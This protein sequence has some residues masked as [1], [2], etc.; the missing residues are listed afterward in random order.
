[1]PNFETEGEFLEEDETIRDNGL[2][3]LQAP[4]ISLNAFT[5][6]NNFKTL[7]VTGVLGKNKIHILIDYGSTHNFLDKNKA[8]QLRSNIRNMCP[9]SVTVAE[10]NKLV[11]TS[12][13]K[14]F[15]WQFGA[16][17]FTTDVMLLPLGGCDMREMLRGAHKS[18]LE[19]LSTKVSDK[20]IR[21]AELNFIDMCVFPN[22]ASTCM[23]LEKTTTDVHLI[24][25]EVIEEYEDV[26]AIPKELPPKRD[27]D[28]KIPLIEGAQPVNIR[29]YRHPPTQ[30]D[31]IEEMVT[32]LLQTRVIQNSNSPFSSL[33]VM[34]D[35]RFGYHQVR[36][37]DADIAKTAFK[38]HEGNYEFLVMPFGLTNA[39]FTFQSLMN[40]VF[41]QYLRKFVSVFFD[42]IL[43]Y[44]QIVEDHVLH[45]RAVLEIM[46]HHKLFAK[47]SKCVFGTDKVK[48]L[49][50]VIST[51]GVAT[52]PIKV[53]VMSQWPV[54][55]N[56]KQLRA[57]E[58]LKQAMV[59]ASVLKLS[60]FSKEFTLETDA[61]GVGLGAILLQEG[62][63]IAFLSK[64]LS[65][66]HQLMS[67]YEK[68][69]LAIIYALEK[70]RG[71]LLHSHF[72]IKTDHLS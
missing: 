69:F 21:Q 24:L 41:R 22:S 14:Q 6:S 48:Y 35:L 26:F 19:W 9:L 15:K 23:Q 57:F 3:D 28:H 33:I 54:P 20:T 61:S 52:D 43:I 4:L 37:N 34:L 56:L 49:G 32:E 17:L 65:S 53:E 30:K 10:G 45:L 66:K 36:M 8:K 12:E 50:H 31:A 13:C 11:T 70:W 16:N 5:G 18:N 46:R 59:R 40:E 25:Q 29:P 27:H 72:K 71:Y 44:S 2:V 63:P 7:R 42:D 39:P 62:H 67:T 55:T 58:Q 64:T 1:M 68:E 38:T 51:K 47:G 60:D